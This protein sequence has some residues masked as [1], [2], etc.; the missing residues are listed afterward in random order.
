MTASTA[1]GDKVL[2]DYEGPVAIISNNNPD[3]RNAFDDDMDLRLFEILDELS[4]RRDIR[5]VIWRGVGHSFSTGRDVSS[6]GATMDVSHHEL[7]R[8]GHRGIAKLFEIDA[9]VIA[10]LQGWSIGGSL[11]RALLC[12]M[13]VAADDAR[14]MLP[15]LNHGVIPDTGG[16]GVLYEMCGHG[17]VSDLVLTGRAMSAAEAYSHGVVSRVV[18]PDQLDSTVRQMAEDIAAKPRVSVSM[19]RRVIRHL[20]EP[21]IRSS[22]AE[23]MIA[24][25]F[26]NKSSDYAEMRAARLEDRAPVYTGS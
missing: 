20:Y 2:L 22:M 4:E 7:M 24:Q 16:V 17:V 8:R 1:P 13:R 9:P 5:A 15:E 11:Q 19:A 6:I 12:D 3:K 21:Q 18:A 23:E 25:T 26:I 14:F 10:A